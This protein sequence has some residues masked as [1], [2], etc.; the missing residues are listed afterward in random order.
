[1][2]GDIAGSHS[3]NALGLCDGRCLVRFSAEAQIILTEVFR[4]ILQLLQTYIED[5]YLSKNNMASYKFFIFK[6]FYYL[7]LHS[8]AGRS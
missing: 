4:D 7:M 8:P 3:G 1:M 5:W 2:R 6:L